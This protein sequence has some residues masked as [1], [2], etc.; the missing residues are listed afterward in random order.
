MPAVRLAFRVEGDKW[1]AYL[2]KMDT[3]DEAIWMGSIAM[4][5]VNSDDTRKRW[6]MDL[7]KSALS[8]FA[9]D[10][11]ITIASWNEYEAPP[12]ERSGSA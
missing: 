11:G 3:M 8:D 9:Q 6:F 4:G 7:M 1:V 10:N 5:I 2:A 12:H